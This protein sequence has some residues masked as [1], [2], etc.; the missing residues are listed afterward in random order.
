MFYVYVLQSQTKIDEL[1]TGY[2]KDLKNRLVKHNKGDITHTSKYRPWTVLVYVAFKSQTLAL[3][4]EKYLKSGSGRAFL[5][6]RLITLHG[7]VA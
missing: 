7:E 4:F 3:N 1:Y 2:T 5:K 6:K